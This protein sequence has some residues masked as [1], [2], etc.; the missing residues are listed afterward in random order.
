VGDV[1]L[2]RAA[3][4]WLQ[5]NDTKR[6]HFELVDCYYGV[7]GQ[8]KCRTLGVFHDNVRAKLKGLLP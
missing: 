6:I 5:E 2:G 8:D 3:R 4:E 1:D 7:H